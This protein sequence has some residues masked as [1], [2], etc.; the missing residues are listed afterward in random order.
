MTL[1]PE[2]E[3]A[4]ELLGILEAVGAKVAMGHSDAT[5]DET[6]RAVDRGVR[7]AVHT[8]NAMRP[9][10]HREPGIAG[11]VLSEDRVWAE[12]IV[13][14]VHVAPELVKVFAR[15]KGPD[16]V[17]LVTDGTSAAG[18]PD[19]TYP[20]GG[21]AVVVVD[22]VARDHE[23]HLA[24][25]TLT[26]DQALRNFLTWTRWDLGDALPSLTINPA[27]AAGLAG[28]G[29]IEVGAAADLVLLDPEFRV[30][31][32]YVDGRLVYDAPIV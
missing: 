9:I 15:A 3:G 16:R 19:G 6:R 27:R 14:G 28:A 8:F 29:A 10:H 20:L 24:G 22:G 13:D 2:I 12:I 26:Q 7:Y 30:V 18:M 11:L 32:T 25:S 31:R 23:G 5:A 17:L 4:D 1:A 21:S